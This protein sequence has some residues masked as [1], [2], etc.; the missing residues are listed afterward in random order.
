MKAILAMLFLPCLA[1]A[2]GP[3]ASAVA[4]GC[5]PEG[6]K[7]DV[8]TDKQQHPMAPPERGK[9]VLYFIEDDRS[10]ESKPAPT[11]RLGVDGN[12]VGATHGNSYLYVAVDP[13]EHHLCASWQSKVVL[14]A[15]LQTA[16]AHFTAEAGKAYYFSAR[17]NWNQHSTT[18]ID[19]G[20]LDDDEAQLLMSKFPIST[21]HPK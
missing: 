2:Q 6:A 17:N 5:G 11:T 9:A 20:P 14:G 13:G 1:F 12:W 4:P 19:L 10:F 18:G 15:G 21:S 8:K 3:A 7:F 16:A